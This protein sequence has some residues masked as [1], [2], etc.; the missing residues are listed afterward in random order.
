MAEDSLWFMFDG[1]LLLLHEDGAGKR[2][3]PH[4]VVQPLPSVNPAR[5]IGEYQGT[6][7][8]SVALNIPPPYKNAAGNTGAAGYVGVT[9]HYRA[10]ELM[11]KELYALAAKAGE[12]AYWDTN[13]QFCPACGAK[14]VSASNICKKCPGCG[15]ELFPP[16][17]VAVL[18]VVVRKNS[19]APGGD[20]ILLARAHRFNGPYYSLLAG[21]VEAGETLETCVRREVFEETSLVVNNIRY[22]GSQPWPHP[23]NLMVGFF[24]DYVSGEIRIQESELLSANFFRRDNLPALPH[25]FSLSRQLI[26]WW[27]SG[28]P[29][30]QGEVL[31]DR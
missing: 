12:I 14:T 18:A 28:K 4:G 22:F 2:S 24:A 8:M 26:N 31:T 17:S 21:F 9:L 10:Y 16:I 3:L 7:C 13:S 20:E 11:G 27:K 30:P 5:H 25:E 1:P 23:S 29:L 19:A 15:K 6:P